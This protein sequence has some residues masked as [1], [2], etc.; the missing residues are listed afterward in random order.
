MRKYNRYFVE[1]LCA[2]STWSR[3]GREEGFKTLKEAKKHIKDRRRWC[4][5]LKY[6]LVKLEI[7]ESVVNE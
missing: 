5:H 6:R 4:P 1:L 3:Y 7:K 2:D